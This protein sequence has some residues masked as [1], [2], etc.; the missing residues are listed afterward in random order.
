VADFIKKNHVK[1]IFFESLVSPKLSE[2]IAKETGAQTLAFNPLEGLT[3]SELAAG[4]NY[5]SIQRQNLAALRI[6]LAC[7]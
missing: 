1:Y 7:P 3:P 5:I 4:Q 6:A 2:T